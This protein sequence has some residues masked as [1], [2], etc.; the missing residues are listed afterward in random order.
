MWGRVADRSAANDRSS[1]EVD[2]KDYQ[3]PVVKVEVMIG[4]SIGGGDGK[5]VMVS[6]LG[7]VLK[8]KE[9]SEGM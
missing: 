9:E 5:L 8:L 7:P 6:E 1:I 3:H 2:T 4:L